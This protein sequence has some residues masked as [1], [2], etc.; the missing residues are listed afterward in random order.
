MKESHDEPKIRISLVCAFKFQQGTEGTR[1][2][3]SVPSDQLLNSA[4]C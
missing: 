1:R 3:A 2:S 4:S